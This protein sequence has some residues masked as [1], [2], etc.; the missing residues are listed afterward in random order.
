MVSY[1]SH[2]EALPYCMPVDEIFSGEFRNECKNRRCRDHVEC[3]DK[4]TVFPL[5]LLVVPRNIGCLSHWGLVPDDINYSYVLL[6]EQN[7][8]YI[9]L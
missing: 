9:L 5:L 4:H 1:T 3:H 8:E 7:V 2:S 6:Q